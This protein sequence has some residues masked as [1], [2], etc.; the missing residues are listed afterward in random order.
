MKGFTRTESRVIFFL[1]ITFGAGLGLK[2]YR[3]RWEP[4]PPA[5]PQKKR[6]RISK[7]TDFAEQ[8]SADSLKAEAAETA[9]SETGLININTASASELEELPGIGPVIAG[10]IISYRKE[11]GLFA[12]VKELQNVKGIGPATAAKAGKFA[13]VK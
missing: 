6:E 10:R 8:V 1:I 13:T 3:E 9:V 11:E 4:L 2:I 5:A 7:Q 12:A